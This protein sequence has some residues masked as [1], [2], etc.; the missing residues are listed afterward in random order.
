MS[1]ANEFGGKLITLFPV[2]LVCFMT[3]KVVNFLNKQE[4]HPKI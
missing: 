4:F 1:K 3:V 2:P